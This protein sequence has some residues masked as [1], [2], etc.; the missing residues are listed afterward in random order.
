MS[1]TVITVAFHV[2]VLPLMLACAYCI[3]RAHGILKGK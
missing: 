3:G 2:V 1:H